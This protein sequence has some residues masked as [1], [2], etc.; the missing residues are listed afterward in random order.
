MVYAYQMPLAQKEQAFAAAKSIGATHIRL[1]IELHRV[2]RRGSRGELRRDWS[3]LD[4]VIALSRLHGL[5]VV[6]ILVGVP[7]FLA[8]CDDG[9][10][11][12]CAA[13][14]ASEYGRLAGEVAEHARGAIGLYEVINEPDSSAMFRGGPEDYARM[15]SSAYDAIKA[16][17]PGSR[18]LLG[19]VSDLEA[20]SW[21]TRVFATPGVR[22]ATKFD[23]ANVHVRGRVSWL[24]GTMSLWRETFAAAGRSGVP[25]WVTEHGYPADTAYQHDPAYQGG[26]AAQAAYLRDSLPVLVRAGVAQVFVSTRDT[27]PQEFGSASPFASEGVFSQAASAPYSTRSRPATSV[28]RMLAGQWPRVPHTVMEEGRLTAARNTEA[29]AA[30]GLAR[31]RGELERRVSRLRRQVSELRRRAARAGRRSHPREVRALRVR[32]RRSLG[33]LTRVKRS[34]A[35]VASRTTQRFAR[36]LLYQTRLRLGS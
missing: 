31:Q 1:D 15:L 33:E 27:W 2:F 11:F 4:Q 24:R 10:T 7:H 18:V 21:L 12:R 5:P 22:A 32:I 35:S 6:A 3:G 34:R 9:A 36:L 26:E 20:R 23:I 25:L 28:I 30:T 19:G 13:D 16:R 29:A 14:D 17:S 8:D